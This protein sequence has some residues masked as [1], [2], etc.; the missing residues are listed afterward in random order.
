MRKFVLDENVTKRIRS[1]M[2]EYV[3][4]FRFLYHLN[5]DEKTFGHNDDY[6]IK[7]AQKHGFTIITRDKGLVLKALSLSHDIV[8]QD[9]ELYRLF[10][11]GHVKQIDESEFGKIRKFTKEEHTQVLGLGESVG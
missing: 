8:W 11:G 1:E 2:P 7:T 4:N 10:Y 5:G 3:I 6:F 9:G